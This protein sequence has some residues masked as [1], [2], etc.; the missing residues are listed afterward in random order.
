MPQPKAKELVGLTVDELTEKY[1]ALKKE[2]FDLRVQAKLQK[3]HDLSRMKKA[4]RQIAR[5]LTVKSQIEKK[6]AP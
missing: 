3:L 5:V 1:E 4:R 6:A 2:M